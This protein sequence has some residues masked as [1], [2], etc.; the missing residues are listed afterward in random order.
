MK[1]PEY[2]MHKE[3]QRQTHGTEQMKD[4]ATEMSSN[5]SKVLPNLGE[6]RDCSCI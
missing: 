6:K 5:I 2:S 4:G 3:V 1:V